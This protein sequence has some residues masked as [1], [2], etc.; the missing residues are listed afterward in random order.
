M[1]CQLNR[2][3]HSVLLNCIS[4]IQLDVCTRVL[5][6]IADVVQKADVYD[7]FSKECQPEMSESV[8]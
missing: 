7:V 6:R 3:K 2:N 1:N 8:R 5:T 4:I